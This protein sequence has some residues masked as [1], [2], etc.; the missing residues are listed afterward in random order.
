MSGVED[1]VLRGMSKTLEG[2]TMFRVQWLHVTV[3][4]GCD[5][6][7]VIRNFLKKFDRPGGIRMKSEDINDRDEWM[8]LLEAVEEVEEIQLPS[9]G[10]FSSVIR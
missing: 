4:P 2:K 8:L 5:C 7:E 9:G 3:M 10:W 6:I 1:A